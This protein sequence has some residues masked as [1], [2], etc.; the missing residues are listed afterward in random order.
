MN[1]H[2]DAAPGS[3]AAAMTSVRLQVDRDNVLKARSAILTEARRLQTAVRIRTPGIW[4]GLCGGDPVSKDAKEAFNE[5]IKALVDHCM[6]YALDLETA[7][8]TL[9]DIARSY[10]HTEDDIAAS[11]KQ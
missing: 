6:Q 9:D 5:R 11:F 3:L 2:T 1:A 8:Y 4:V 7:G 10:G